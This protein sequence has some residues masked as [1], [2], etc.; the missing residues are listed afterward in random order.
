MAI[1]INPKVLARLV[2]RLEARKSEEVPFDLRLHDV[3]IYKPDGREGPTVRRLTP[4]Q[5]HALVEG[6]NLWAIKSVVKTT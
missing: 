5:T 6:L 1:S 4:G 3:K 2:A